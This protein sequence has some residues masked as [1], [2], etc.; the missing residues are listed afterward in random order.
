MEVAAGAHREQREKT[1]LVMFERYLY[2][3]EEGGV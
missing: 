1:A 3:G 2:Q